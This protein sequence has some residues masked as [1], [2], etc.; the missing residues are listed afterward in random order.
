MGNWISGSPGID[1][2][3]IAKIETASVESPY[4]AA[5]PELRRRNEMYAMLATEYTTSVLGYAPYTSH[6]VST[7]HAT[8]YKDHGTP[9]ASDDPEK[10]YHIVGRDQAIEMTHAIRRKMDHIVFFTDFGLSSG[11]RGAKELAEREGI[12]VLEVKLEGLP[13]WGVRLSECGP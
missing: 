10:R 6:L 9:Y 3:A 12:D 2:G 13:G 8:H 4:W 11:M 1:D 7:T 5:T